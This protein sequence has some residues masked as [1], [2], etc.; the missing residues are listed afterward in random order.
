[1]NPLNPKI[2]PA[3]NP[4]LS[5]KPRSVFSGNDLNVSSPLRINCVPR[6]TI[7]ASRPQE[8]A[9]ATAELTATRQAMF[10]KGRILVNTQE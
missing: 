4:E 8:S 6:E 1:M 5:D 10:E 7:K 9:A 3:D 2:N